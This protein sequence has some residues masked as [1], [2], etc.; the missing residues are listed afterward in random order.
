VYY[1]ELFI[2][3]T[4]FEAATKKAQESQEPF[5]IVAFLWLFFPSQIKVGNSVQTT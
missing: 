1:L 4:I 5:V 3:A 2:L